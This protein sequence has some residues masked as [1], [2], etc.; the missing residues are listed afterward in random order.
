MFKNMLCVLFAIGL[1]VILMLITNVMHDKYV[2]VIKLSYLLDFFDIVCKKINSKLWPSI[3][4][5]KQ[6][7][8]LKNEPVMLIN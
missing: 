2:K 6:P 5:I 7:Y 4:I 3:K 1:R 8:V